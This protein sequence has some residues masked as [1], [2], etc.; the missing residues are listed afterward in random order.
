M[1]RGIRGATTVSAND[2]REILLHTKR[3]VEEMI[4]TND[5]KSEQVSHALVSVTHD[6]NAT[7]PAKAI[8]NLPGWKYVP[9]MNMLEIDV[10]GSLQKCIRIMMVV[11]TEKKQEDI[12]H[13]YHNDAVQLRP[14]L[15]KTEESSQ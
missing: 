7:F 13:I 5:L 12:H 14:D 8:R 6:L 10:P 15:Q 4:A 3:L 2:E 9:V 11:N 1:T